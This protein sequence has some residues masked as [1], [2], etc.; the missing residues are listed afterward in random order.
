MR[1]V[2]IEVAQTMETGSFINSLRQ[3]MATHGKR[4]EMRLDNGTNFK[5][6]NSKLTEA[7]KQRNHNNLNAF[8]LQEEIRWHFNPPHASHM[9]GAWERPIRTVR[10]VS[11][12][13][14]KEQVLDDEGLQMLLCGVESVING[15]PST[16]VSDDLGDV[17][18]LTPNHLFLLKS[19]Y[20]MPPGVFSKSDCYENGDG[21]SFSTLQIF[22]EEMNQRV[23]TN[24]ADTTK[25]EPH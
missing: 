6:G 9:G 17:T 22:L 1:V 11:S 2:H 15:R 19:N 12:G 24:I 5:G 20:C 23:F 25:V 18:A 4:E 8:F 14:L 3:F 13:P 7:I 16:K 10:K 21:N